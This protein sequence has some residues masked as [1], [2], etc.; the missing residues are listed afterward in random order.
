MPRCFIPVDPNTRQIRACVHCHL[1]TI[2]Y[3]WLVW[4]GSLI[5]R[6]F[7]TIALLIFGNYIRSA[8]TL[9]YIYLNF[10][11][12]AQRFRSFHSCRNKIL[13]TP[14]RVQ[15]SRCAGWWQA[16]ISTQI[17]ARRLKVP[18]LWEA[19]QNKQHDLQYHGCDLWSQ[20]RFSHAPELT[21]I[22][23]LWIHWAMVMW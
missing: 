17:L 14:T 4:Y 19:L 20:T 21:T 9:P 13:I 11:C 1:F 2:A 10:T 12:P 8:L 18:K 15:A 23:S 16:V 5:M 3:Q 7:G 22:D 6:L